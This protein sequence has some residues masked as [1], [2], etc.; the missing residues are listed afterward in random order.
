MAATISYGPTWLPTVSAISHYGR[1][2]LVSAGYSI[3]SLL[4]DPLHVCVLQDPAITRHDRHTHGH[5]CGNDDANSRVFVKR[6]GQSDR[7][8]RD[9]VVD[10]DE[11]QEREGLGLRDPIPGIHREHEP[12]SRGQQSDLPGADTGDVDGSIDRS[13]SDDGS[14]FGGE[15]AWIA[16]PPHPHV[17]VEDDQRRASQSNAPIGF[18]GFLYL[19]T[20][21]LS[22]RSDSV[23]SS[24][25]GTT[26]R[27]G[28]P[29]SVMMTGLQVLSTWRKYSSARA[30]NLDFEMPPL[31]FV[32]M[33]LV[34]LAWSL[35]YGSN[36]AAPGCARRAR[37][38]HRDWVARNTQTG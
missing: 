22:S 19:T 37:D 31:A 33:T 2:R 25:N 35:V 17:G 9:G 16:Q 3:A 8:D 24:E 14:R 18:V 26:L 27:T 36:S 12:I 11:M 10:R 6:I 7:A 15:D 38:R 32:V 34:I 4:P 20:E 21:F 29:R 1:S 13:L 23:G 5:G 28:F 30:L